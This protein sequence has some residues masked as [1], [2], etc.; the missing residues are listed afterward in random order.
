MEGNVRRIAGRRSLLRAGLAVAAVPFLA[1]CGGAASPTAGP[2]AAVPPGGN[3][4]P[5]KP[6]AAPTTAP[7]AAATTAPAAGATT[8]PAAAATTAPAAATKPA[9]AATTAPAAGA[10]TSA[11]A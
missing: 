6:A 2:K 5:T 11:P 4:E 10:A 9:A 3:P 7:A 1:A 8:A